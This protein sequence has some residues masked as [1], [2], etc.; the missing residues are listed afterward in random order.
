M[1]N[2]RL[3]H[4]LL[5]ASI[6]TCYAVS[7]AAVD[8]MKWPDT[9]NL[10]TPQEKYKFTIALTAL[11]KTV[12]TYGTYKIEKIS[13]ETMSTQRA[14][15]ILRMGTSINAYTALTTSEWEEDT[16][17]IRIPIRRGLLNYR[18]LL[19]HKNNLNMFSQVNTAAELMK[20]KVGSQLGW[21]TT[22][23]LEAEGFNVVRGK[24]LDGMFYMLDGN[25]FDYL[26]RG[27]NEAFYDLEKYKNKLD[28]TVEPRLTLNIP[29]PTYIFI[30]P[31]EKRLAKRINDGLEIMVKDGTLKRLFYKAYSEYIEQ[32]NLK[33]RKVLMIK[34]S[35][36]SPKT[37]WDRPELWYDINESPL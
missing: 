37:P 15:E 7:A 33:N 17:P 14:R 27:I 29:A 36:L 31:N 16:I 28:I 18:L 23:I 11:K 26:P 5:F 32:A 9:G 20:I 21:A 22:G 19:V 12:P 35:S 30:A 13:I 3:L 24:K 25:R 4:K 6:L 2:S 34:N 1:L 10:D 8:V